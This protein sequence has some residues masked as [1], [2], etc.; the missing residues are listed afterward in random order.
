VVG[1]SAQDGA[2]LWKA[3]R[4]ANIAVI[5][6]PLVAGNEIYV[7]SG[8]GAGCNLYKVSQND[9][10]FSADQVYANH[11]MVN[12]HGGVV[13]VGDCIYGYSEG[14]GL[15]CQNAAT[16]A[17][18]L[19]REDQDQE[20]FRVLRDGKLYCREEDTGTVILVNTAPDRTP[21]KAV[22]ANR[23]APRPSLVSSRDRETGS[24]TLRDQDTLLCYDLKAA[25]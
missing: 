20:R 22:L 19:G 11:V 18:P 14:K 7:T 24:S 17:G 16:G 10:K 25:P 21:K 13:W 23:T 1:I 15:T 3:R 8:Y 12:H 6:T 4:Q 9:G 5:P 2:L